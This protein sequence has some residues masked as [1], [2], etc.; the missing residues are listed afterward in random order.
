VHSTA[1]LFVL[2][3]FLLVACAQISTLCAPFAVVH[4]V[5]KANEAARLDQRR[6][7]LSVNHKGTILQVN[8]GKAALYS[9]AFWY[10]LL[11]LWDDLVVGWV[12]FDS[13]VCMHTSN[14][15]QYAVCGALGPAHGVALV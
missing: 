4:Q 3:A 8:P 2:Q 12:G 11:C 14:A 10:R 9:T 6:L 1:L 5:T 15:A 7:L 13:T